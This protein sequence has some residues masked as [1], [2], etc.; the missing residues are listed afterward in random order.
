MR[1]V[2]S[3]IEFKQIV[4]RGTR[5]F[6]GKDYFTIYDFV[7]A[8][9]NFS[10]PE[11]DGEP[12]DPEICPKCGESPCVCKPEAC[13]ECGQFP[14]VCEPDPCPVC[15]ESPCVCQ[16]E[17]CDV[18]GQD[19][20]ICEKKQKVVVKLANGKAR[21][22]QKITATMFW[23]VDGKPM[24]AKEFIE[25]LF[26]ALPD[27]FKDEDELK[28]LWSRPDT[29]KKLLDGL[30]DRGYDRGQLR[31]LG[32]I[33]DAKDSDLFDV[34]AYIAYNTKPI[35]REERVE[36]HREDIFGHYDEKQQQFLSFVLDHYVG[37]GVGQLDEDNLT[38]LIKLRYHTP[39]DAVAELGSVAVIRETFIGFQEYLY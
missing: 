17:P 16:T 33:V 8:Y 21:E 38:N 37:Q 19:P 11:W 5:L 26:G 30:A 15:G 39:S 35:S 18:C 27:L 4:G 13:P 29:R 24:S 2:N 22:I 31:E 25:K 6:D 7:Q 10:D 9:K 36:A 20:C 32:S 1:P 3:I 34:L 14:C 12:E 28:A 23:G